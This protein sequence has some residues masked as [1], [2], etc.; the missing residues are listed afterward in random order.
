MNYSFIATIVAQTHLGSVYQYLNLAHIQSTI[1]IV[2]NR[3]GLQPM[4]A[5][6]IYGI[7][8]DDDDGFD[9]HKIMHYI[10]TGL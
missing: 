2:Y 1:Y 4:L 7:K 10:E 3:E 5:W 8:N 6:T 9:Y